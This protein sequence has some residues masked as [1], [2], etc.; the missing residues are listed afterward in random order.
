MDCLIATLRDISL[1][2]QHVLNE[3]SLNGIKRRPLPK[4]AKI[5]DLHLPIPD[6]RSDLHPFALKLEGEDALKAQF[7]EACIQIRL[8]VNKRYEMCC[9]ASSFTQYDLLRVG[10]VFEGQ[11]QKYITQTRQDLLSSISR[12][13]LRR[14]VIY[15]PFTHEQKA[16]PPSP[17]YTPS[18]KRLKRTN[19]QRRVFTPE[20]EKVLEDTFAKQSSIKGQAKKDLA[21]KLGVAPE[22]VAIWVC[23]HFT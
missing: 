9:H 16:T 1:Q 10:K 8:S 2:A 22:K 18:T 15:I 23:S 17:P 3:G 21:A 12:S 4:A 20:A 7:Q 14:N 6:I 13:C 11:F 5:P 19:E